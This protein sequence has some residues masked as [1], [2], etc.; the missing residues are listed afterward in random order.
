MRGL[1][2]KVIVAAGA[3]G[4][5][6]A[7]A[8]RRLAD[9]GARVVVGDVDLDGATAT[10]DAIK[11]DGGQAVAV[12]YDQGDEAS[13]AA[14]IAQAVDR[15]GRL[16]GLFANAANAGIVPRDTDLLAIDLEIWERSLRIDLTGCVLLIRHA[17]P[18]LLSA[19]GGAILC[20]SS[21]AGDM[22]EPERPAY[23]AAKAGVNAVVRHV[24]SRW[25]KEG[26]RAN[27]MCPFAMSASVRSNLDEAFLAQ[28]REETP[29]TH[30]AEPAEMVGLVAFLLSEDAE[31]VNGQIWSI[32]GGHYLRA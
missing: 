21:D 28:I 15:Y 4:G 12:G 23:A 29:S 26:I 25:G 22:G 9:E 32:N 17:L 8:A 19:G 7:A 20:T 24:A 30:L 3:G 18:H 2:D 10:A 13:V 1:A 14:L 11:Q 16:D 6:G 5:I 27:A 31:Y